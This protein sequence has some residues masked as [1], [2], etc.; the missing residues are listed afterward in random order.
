[1]EKINDIKSSYI[2]SIVCSL[3]VFGIKLHELTYFRYIP[4]PPALRTVL[5]WQEY[6]TNESNRASVAKQTNYNSDYC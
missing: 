1:M 4:A 3:N 5:E 2:R 6:T